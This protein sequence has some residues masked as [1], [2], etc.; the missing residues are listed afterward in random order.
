MKSKVNRLLCTL[1]LCTL[2]VGCEEPIK[3]PRY[4]LTTIEYIPD[5]LKAQHREWIKETVRAS[6]QHLS[7]GD[8][9]DVDETIV[10]AERTANRIFEVSVIGLNKEIDDNNWNDLK[11]KPNELSVY[12]KT[13]LDSLTR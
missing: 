6:N 1:I 7:A 10:Q 2:F 11:L 12:E 13:V 4:S 5:S 9:E 8:Y 3:Y